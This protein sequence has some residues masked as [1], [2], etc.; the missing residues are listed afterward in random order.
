MELIA[1][2]SEIYDFCKVFLDKELIKDESKSKKG[3]KQG[4]HVSEIMT[5]LVWY[6]YSKF[7]CFKDFY[8]VYVKGFRNNEFPNAPSYTRFLE[9]K[10]EIME[11]MMLYAVLKNHAET[12]GISIIDSFSIEACHIK[13]SSSHKTLKGI[14]KKGKTSM[15]WFF[16]LK[17]HVVINAEGEICS[18]AI[19]PGNVADNNESIL[20]YLTKKIFG[21]LFGDKGYLV[22]AEVY[23][24]LYE[25]GV[26]LI[27]KIKKNM[28]NKFYNL[29]D[30][31]M[32]KKRGV[33][34][35]V[36]NV[37]KNLFSLE[38][39]RHRSVAGVFIHIFSCLI[40][41]AFKKEKPSIF[42][43]KLALP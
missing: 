26:Q 3:R 7:K 11:I 5:I 14:A 36:G 12:N 2:F 15:G 6:H 37:L 30:A 39:S 38:H 24:K 18:F 23:K 17:L 1:I 34:E 8:M 19:T 42:K 33:V 21:K 27:T 10:N 43:K 22:R 32:L 29:H 4:L 13:R 35:S 41:Y 31:L 28:K 20:Y 9:L 40:A 25:N 16:G